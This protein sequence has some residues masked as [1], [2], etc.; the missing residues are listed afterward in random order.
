MTRTLR[1]I[2][3]EPPVAA[4]ARELRPRGAAPGFVTIQTR[5]RLNGKA[6]MALADILVSEEKLERRSAESATRSPSGAQGLIAP[7]I[8]NIPY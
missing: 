4:G 3:R 8:P 7:I 5:Y 1:H 2:W 6:P